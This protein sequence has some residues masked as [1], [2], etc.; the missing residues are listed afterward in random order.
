MTV[1]KPTR[2][3]Q[4]L[5]YIQLTDC[6]RSCVRVGLRAC[7]RVCARTCVCVCACVRAHACVFAEVCFDSFI[8]CFVIGSVVRF[9]KTTHKS[10]PYYYYYTPLRFGCWPG[11]TT[12][13]REGRVPVWSRPRLHPRPAPRPQAGSRR[14]GPQSPPFPPPPTSRTSATTSRTS[15]TTSRTSATTSTTTPLGTTTSA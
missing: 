3:V 8:L 1:Y 9:G 5:Q 6:V 15:A 14:E 12:S 10:V 2:Q 7:V 4:S 11:T 13:H